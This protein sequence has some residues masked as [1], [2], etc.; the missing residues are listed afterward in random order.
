MLTLKKSNHHFCNF[1]QTGNKR[2]DSFKG[3]YC[4]QYQQMALNHL[5]VKNCYELNKEEG[6]DLNDILYFTHELIIEKQ[7]PEQVALN[8]NIN[9]IALSSSII[10]VPRQFIAI[11]IEF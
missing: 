3:T 2:D 7:I 9:E 6:M 10:V 1:Y 5:K 4:E 11:Q 8:K